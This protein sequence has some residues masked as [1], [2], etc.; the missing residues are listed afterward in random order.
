MP[1][2]GESSELARIDMDSGIQRKTVDQFTIACDSQSGVAA[3]LTLESEGW[4]ATVKAV[5]ESHL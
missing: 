2:R 3:M 4:R 1:Y 5:E